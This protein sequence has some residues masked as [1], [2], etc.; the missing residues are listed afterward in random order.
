MTSEEMIKA[1]TAFERDAR[2]MF[3]AS[4]VAEGDAVTTGWAETTQPDWNFA[5]FEYRPCTRKYT[6]WKKLELEVDIE[7]E[8]AADAHAAML[9]MDDG[10]PEF[11]VT[12]C[13]HGLVTENLEYLSLEEYEEYEGRV[14]EGA[15][16]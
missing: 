13:D 7:A 11:S 16:E 6:V 1:I 8:S 10:G 4:F 14:D 15:G 12:G 9:E 5:E 2:V 3:R